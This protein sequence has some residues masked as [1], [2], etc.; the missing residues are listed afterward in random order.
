MFNLASETTRQLPA[1]PV[2]F[3]VGVFV[4]FVV[5]LYLVLRLDN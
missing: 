1:T 2:Q 4:V 3:G 5:L